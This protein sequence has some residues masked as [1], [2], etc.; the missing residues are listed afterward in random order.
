MQRS[1]FPTW[2]VR[3]FRPLSF[4]L[5]FSHVRLTEM[6][7]KSSSGGIVQWAFVASASQ[8]TYGGYVCSSHKIH[9][10]TNTQFKLSL[11]RTGVCSESACPFGTL[12][13][14]S[15]LLTG[16]L[17][18][19]VP[20]ASTS[21]APSHTQTHTTLL[22]ALD[23]AVKTY[24]SYFSGRSSAHASPIDIMNSHSHLFP[25]ICLQTWDS[26]EPF[27]P[28]LK[29][30]QHKIVMPEATLAL[31]ELQLSG[32]GD[33]DVLKLLTGFART[34]RVLA[35]VNIGYVFGVHCRSDGRYA[36]FDTHSKSLSAY[37]G[38]A[39]SGA[40]VAVVATARDALHFIT[41]VPLASRTAILAALGGGGGGGGF[42]QDESASNFDVA[43]LQLKSGVKKFVHAPATTP[44]P[45]ST[46]ATDNKKAPEANAK[47]QASASA[48][49]PAAA[50]PT[51]S[52]APAPATAAAAA[53]GANASNTDAAVAGAVAT[54]S[55]PASAE[56]SSK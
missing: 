7:Q 35:I 3:S 46:A 40:Y 21:P 42:M 49:A 27:P 33:A 20:P 24:R 48:A 44:A 32:V 28:E 45:A 52:V 9:A 19:A 51:A 2:Y 15:R 4:R 1:L 13:L 23:S 14:A 26:I 50:A 18:P 29:A 6:E 12:E 25:S 47:E 17:S 22:S 8:F 30:V 54:A 39:R 31:G 36:I 43:V 34:D 55:L 41:A 38:E 11:A 5:G 56:S 10:L 53:A 16:E 37:T